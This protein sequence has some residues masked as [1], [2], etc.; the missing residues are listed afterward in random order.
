MPQITQLRFSHLIRRRELPLPNQIIAIEDVRSSSLHILEQSEGW[1]I[2][3][4]TKQHKLHIYF[5]WEE[6]M[7]PNEQPKY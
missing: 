1:M 2:K 6:I 5:T 7:L 3:V 4:A